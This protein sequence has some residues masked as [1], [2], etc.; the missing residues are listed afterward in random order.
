[1]TILTPRPAL[2]RATWRAQWD[3][4]YRPGDIDEYRARRGRHEGEAQFFRDVPA[5]RR[6]HVPGNLLMYGGVSCLWQALI[7]N[8]TATAAQTLTYFNN[9]NAYFGFGDGSQSAL[10][11]TA[12]VTNGSASVTTSASQASLIGNYLIFTGDSSNGVYLVSSGSGTSWTLSSNYGGST[13][14]TAAFTKIVG[15]VATQ[16]DLQAASNKVR[17]AMDSTYPQH[18]DATTSGAASI[19]FQGTLASGDGNWATGIYEVG[20]FNGS[21]GG[22]MLNRKIANLGIKT[23]GNT[24]SGKLTI[25]IT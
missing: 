5:S 16:T 11:G 8:G 18:T 12:S 7:G 14:A 19:I 9:G 3:M 6:I 4:I 2:E 25:T 22:R 1:V 21:S 13:N 23:A 10:T 15:E 24:A 17:K 20:V